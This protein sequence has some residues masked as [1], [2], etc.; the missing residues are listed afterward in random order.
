MLLRALVIAG[1][2]TCSG[3]AFSI[4]MAEEPSS[5]NAAALSG[6]NFQEP[7]DGL[8]A[9]SRAMGVRFALRDEPP[10]RSAQVTSDAFADAANLDHRRFELQA[11]TSAENSGLPV[12]VSLTQR[13][14]LRVSED[15]DVSRSGTGAEVR[16]GRGLARLANSFR[17]ANWDSPTWYFFAAGDN[18]QLAWA[19]NARGRAVSYTEDRVEIG[20]MQVGVAMETH[21]LQASIAYV[22]RDI[23]GKYGSA[24]ENFT[25]V[26]LTWRR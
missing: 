8:A 23:Q 24:E 1:A 14:T 5:S 7:N 16:V 4:A 25:G 26:T 11:L 13:A 10:A 6:V 21:G 9:F 22:Q 12:D 18:E 17:D 15:G 19:P 20:D 3:L 2:L